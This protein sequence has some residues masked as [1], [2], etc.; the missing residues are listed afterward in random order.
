M[1]TNDGWT[2]ASN[3]SVDIAGIADFATLV[4]E[5]LDANFRPNMERVIAEHR[6]GP[7]FGARSQSDDMK[8]AVQKYRDCLSAAIHNLQAYVDGAEILIA[9]ARKVAAMYQSTDALSSAEL[10]KVEDALD[11]AIK[12]ADGARDQAKRRAADLGRLTGEGDL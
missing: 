7:G 2:T 10:G 1:Y 8:V 9:A 6:N 11:A 4:R 12:E 3:I 5:E